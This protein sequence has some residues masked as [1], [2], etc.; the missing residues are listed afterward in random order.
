[1]QILLKLHMCFGHGLKTCM[2]FRY[3]PQVIVCHLFFNLNFL[4]FFQEL[5]LNVSTYV[6]NGYL[7]R[8]TPPTNFTFSDDSLFLENILGGGHKFFNLLVLQC[9]SSLTSLFSKP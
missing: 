5:L 4:V 6:N 7:E 3:N 8:V 1:M 9:F 2:W